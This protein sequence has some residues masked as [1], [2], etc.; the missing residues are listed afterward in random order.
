MDKDK[1]IESL[2]TLRVLKNNIIFQFL[3]ETTD[4]GGFQQKTKDS[5][6]IVETK[7]SQMDRPRWG[8]VIS[9]GNDVV[10]VKP[11]DYIYV[12][13]LQWSPKFMYKMEKFW[14]TND[15]QILAVTEEYPSLDY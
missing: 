1:T 7:G 13:A 14:T 3:E 11:N 10:D 4:S 5:F 6:I 2:K 15:E 8:R 9:V 12:K